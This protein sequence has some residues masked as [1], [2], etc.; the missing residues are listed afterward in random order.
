MSLRDNQIGQHK[1]FENMIDKDS[2]TGWIDHVETGAQRMDNL[3]EILDMVAK[4]FQRWEGRLCNF[5][6]SRHCI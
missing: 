2:D 5:D 6:M 4:F 3:K 1:E